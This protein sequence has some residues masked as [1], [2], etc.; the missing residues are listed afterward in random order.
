MNIRTID[1]NLIVA[2]GALLD[3]CNVSRAA[4]KIGRSQPATSSALARLREMFN[5]PLLVRHGRGYRLTPRAE[6]LRPHVARAIAALTATFQNPA[7]FDPATADMVVR[8]AASDYLAVVLM[9]RLIA[10]LA[11]RAPGIDLRV[12]A[13]DRRSAVTLLREGKVDVSLAVTEPDA[14]DV[15][16]RPLFDEEFVMVTRP[17]HPYH[18]GPPTP[19]R[20]VTYPGLLVSQAGDGTGVADECLAQ[21]GLQRRVA[22]TVAHFLLAPRLVANSDLVLVIGRRVAETARAELNLRVTALPFPIPSFTA[23]MFWHASTN[24]YAPLAWFRNLVAA[25]NTRPR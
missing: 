11:R 7:D 19:E 9:P 6:E 14:T 18:D 13:A 20:F 12:V 4:A 23:R 2:L 17:G 1:L 25:S 22:V 8:I 10:D 5:D 15:L 3:E 21:L 24:N 16:S